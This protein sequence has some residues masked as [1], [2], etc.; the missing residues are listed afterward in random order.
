MKPIDYRNETFAQVAARI[1][2]DRR[3]VLDAL[4]EYGPCTTRGLAK[5]MGWDVLN[6]RPRVTELVQLD[7][8]DCL[9]TEGREGIYLAHTDEVALE[10]FQVRK[11]QTL[12]PQLQ[13]L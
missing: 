11:H 10:R 12:N 9:D 2:R 6:V 7:F 3:A 8:A 1:E 4:R 13:L 5:C